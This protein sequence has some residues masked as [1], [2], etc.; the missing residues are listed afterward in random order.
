MEGRV[1]APVEVRLR[2]VLADAEIVGAADVGVVRCT[3]D[4]V[5][6]V[7]GDLFVALVDERGD[8]H[9]AVAEA[10][11][12]GASAVVASRPVMPGV[13]VCYVPDT[14]QAYGR[15]CQALA[16]DP[17]RRVRTIGVAGSFGK[18]T[19]GY[20]I[21]SVLNAAGKTTGVLGSLGYCD[22]VELSDPRWTTPPPP[23][24]A[25]WL[26]RMCDNGCSHAV[27]EVSARGLAE[28]RTAGIRFDACCITNLQRAVRRGNRTIDE[29]PVAAR[30]LEQLAPEGVLVANVDDEGA[31]E[32]A[33]AHDGPVVTVG[34]NSPAELTAVPLERHPSE[35]TFLL[36][37][38]REVIPVR[39]TLLGAHNLG[40]C[41]LAAAVGTLYGVRPDAIVRGL[42]S[43]KE[44]PGRLERIECGQPFGVFLDGAR[45]PQ[46]LE[47]CLETLRST[48]AGRLRCIYTALATDA[49]TR[50]EFE[51]VVRRWC[52][53][54]LVV[55]YAG[56]GIERAETIR[57][58]LRE[59]ESGDCLLVVAGEVEAHAASEAED[60]WDDRRL[61]RQTLY[62]LAH[63]TERRTVA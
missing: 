35:Q 10:V 59:A 42:E 44:L 47:A 11:R 22:G 61:I 26:S 5:S 6:C 40:H 24:T 25:A 31:A 13:P 15:I 36:S 53:D 38:G 14:R 2:A 39:T 8:G 23:V 48:T 1:A 41:L 57:R 28:A 7:E 33:A 29:R 43:V 58:A 55:A 12:L 17:S 19:A 9:D 32:L 56:Q 16:G 54:A 62:Q 46:A 45:S 21:A 49:R 51:A 3:T 18:T 27:V 50:I 37:F 30:W 63:E 4:A 60:D 52:D 20:L 34:L